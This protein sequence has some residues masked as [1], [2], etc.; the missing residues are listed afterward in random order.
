LP[1]RRTA[2]ACSVRSWIPVGVL[3]NPQA[4]CGIAAVATVTALHPWE[5]VVPTVV[6]CKRPVKACTALTAL[7]TFES[8]RL[9]FVSR[10]DGSFDRNTTTASALCSWSAVAAETAFERV[11][12]RSQLD[13]GRLENEI[14]R[15]GS[16]LEFG[17]AVNAVSNNDFSSNHHG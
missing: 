9:T 7:S 11:V 3:L 8:D 10:E 6:F 4:D 15:V 2:A 5:V 12:A 16:V 14:P 17:F 13:K 1:T